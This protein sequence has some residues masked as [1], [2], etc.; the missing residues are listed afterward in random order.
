MA[1]KLM[2]NTVRNRVRVFSDNGVIMWRLK[3]GDLSIN[4]LGKEE[5]SDVA[6][7]SGFEPTFGK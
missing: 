3:T 6:R 7:R 1:Q 5:G 4:P 2:G